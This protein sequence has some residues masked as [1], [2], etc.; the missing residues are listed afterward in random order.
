[1][2]ASFNGA[3]APPAE[4]GAGFSAEFKVEVKKY[5]EGLEAIKKITSA[6]IP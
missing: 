4:M 3:P 1:M 5:K 6:G 2:M